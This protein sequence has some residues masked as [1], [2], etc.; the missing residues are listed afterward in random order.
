MHV[1]PFLCVHIYVCNI[2]MC[3]VVCVHLYGCAYLCM[4]AYVYICIYVCV[5][6]LKGSYIGRGRYVKGERLE[7]GV[8]THVVREQKVGWI[9]RGTGSSRREERMRGGREGR[10]PDRDTV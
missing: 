4:H 6:I 5:T 1:C 3:I 9:G 10:G 2:S 8:G 7:E